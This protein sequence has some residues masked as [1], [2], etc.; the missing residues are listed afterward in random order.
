[1]S[2]WVVPLQN[3]IV[4]GIVGIDIAGLIH[5]NRVNRVTHLV[6]IDLRKSRR[7]VKS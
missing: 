7:T 4:G 2:E 6:G 3:A 1:M 5:R